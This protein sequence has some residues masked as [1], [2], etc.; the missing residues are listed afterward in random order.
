M[1]YNLLNYFNLLHP[2]SDQAQASLL[3]VVKH[4]ELRRGQIWLQEGSVC[5]K[6]TFVEKGLLKLFFE[7]GKKEVIINFARENEIMFSAQ[8][9]V[10][11]MPSMYAI[12][13]IEQ[14]TISYIL[15]NDLQRILF[16][17]LELY[18]HY[19]FIMHQ[20]LTQIETHAALLLHQPK[21]RYQSLL[22]ANSWVTDGRLT[23]RL[24]AAYLGVGCNAMCRWRR[25]KL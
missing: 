5:D 23:D 25:L 9:Y 20:T 1:S 11:Q 15:R 6:I 8:S 2:L 22:N 17:H 14:T 18:Q 24:L 21:E 7:S 10:S 4:K 19:T 12:R 16:K 13:A 3:R